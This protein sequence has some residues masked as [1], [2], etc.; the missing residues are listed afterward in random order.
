MKY[1]VK[2]C[3]IS[4]IK[5]TGKGPGNDITE[6]TGVGTTYH[7]CIAKVKKLTRY[8]VAKHMCDPHYTFRRK[9]SK[10]PSSC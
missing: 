2:S 9:E 6:E 10:K 1:G 5:V 3:L 7:Y 8:K 4:F